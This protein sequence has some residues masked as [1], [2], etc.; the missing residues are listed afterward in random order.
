MLEKRIWECKEYEDGK[1][2][3]IRGIRSKEDEGRRLLG[4]V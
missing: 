4:E 3:N 2:E 1:M